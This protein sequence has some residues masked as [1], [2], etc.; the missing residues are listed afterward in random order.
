MGNVY[1]ISNIGSFGENVYKIGLTRRWD[2]DDRIRELY[3]ASVPFPFEIN[4]WIASDK[5]PDVE[6]ALH[7]QFALKRLNKV[8]SF[9]EY[10]NL[11][12][13]EIKETV[14]SLGFNAEWTIAGRSYEESLRIT[15]Q[16]EDGT[17]SKEEYLRKWQRG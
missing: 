14:D 11:T 3:N 5:A 12:I 10:F 6:R 2:R 4:G 7:N 9:K 17:L 16:L 8:N 13:G 1:I 15:K